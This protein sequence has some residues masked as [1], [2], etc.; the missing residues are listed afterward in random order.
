M[1]WTTLLLEQGAEGLV[2]QTII[3]E[4]K[5]KIPFYK[6]QVINESTRVIFELVQI[7]ILQYS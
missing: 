4:V 7:V 2:R 6:K 3:S 5:N 1:Y